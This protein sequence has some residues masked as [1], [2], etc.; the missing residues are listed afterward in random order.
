MTGTR[1]LAAAVGL[2]T[3]GAGVTVT[4]IP[5]APCTALGTPR[6]DRI[7][8]SDTGSEETTMAETG[9]D[10]LA[11]MEMAKTTNLLRVLLLIPLDAGTLEFGASELGAEKL[12]TTELDPDE[13]GT[14]WPKLPAELVVGDATLGVEAPENGG[15]VPVNDSVLP[16]EDVVCADCDMLD[17]TF[18]LDEVKLDA[19]EKATED[20]VSSSDTL[21]GIDAE[22]V[23]EPEDE[24]IADGA[25]EV[26]DAVT[27]L[28][29]KFAIDDAGVDSVIVDIDELSAGV[30]VKLARRLD[31]EADDELGA[32]VDT[33]TLS[34]LMISAA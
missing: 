29:V 19:L 32:E 31:S 21:D 12:E 6:V 2:S 7:C 24:T 18:E 9:Q 8:A 3:V 23:L 22:A 16:P 26:V 10:P 1:A 28:D 4:A 27:E 15:N 30:V 13:V 25:A 14:P 11:L 33:P 17:S 20:A 5:G 34:A